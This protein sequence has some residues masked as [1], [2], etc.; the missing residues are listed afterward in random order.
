MPI[1]SIEENNQKFEL[2]EDET[3]FD[4][5]ENQG[6]TLPHGCLAGS[7][8]ACRVEIIQGEENLRAPSVVEENTIQAIRENYVRIHGKGALDG[9][10]VRLSCRAKVLGDIEIRPL[11]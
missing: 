7:C 6:Y 9:K 10:T 5:L 2:N 11:K 3:L 1:V 4:G 8:G